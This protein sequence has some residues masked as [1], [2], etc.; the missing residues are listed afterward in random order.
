MVA[1]GQSAEGASTVQFAKVMGQGRVST[2]CVLMSR[3]RDLS[4]VRGLVESLL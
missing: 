1:L 4:T 2:C 3:V